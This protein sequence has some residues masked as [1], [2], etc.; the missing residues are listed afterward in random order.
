MI[1]DRWIYLAVLALLA[2]LTFSPALMEIATVAGLIGWVGFKMKTGLRIP[3]EK[4]IFYPF[5]GY[6]LLSSLSFFWSQYPAQS[7]RGIFKVLQQGF[8]FWLAVEAV[9]T[10]QRHQGLLGAVLFLFILTGFDG[11]WQLVSV[12]DFLRHI[13][14]EPASSG[15]RVSASFKNYGLLAAYCVTFLPVLISQTGKSGGKKTLFLRC[16][17][18]ALGLLLLFWTRMRGAWIAFWLGGLFFLCFE[19]KKI[20]LVCFLL[21]SAAGVLAL[22]RAMLIHLDAEGKEQSLVERFYLW[23]RAIEVIEAKPLTGT[24]INTYAVAHQEFD[25]RHNWR[26]RNYYAHNGYL[27]MAA[28]TGLPTL[29]LFLAFLFFYFLETMRALRA[30]RD[31]IE[32]RTLVGMLTG[33]LNFMLF[34]M[35]DTIFHNEVSVLAFW[36]LLGWGMAYRKMITAGCPAGVSSP[37][38]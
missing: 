19:R 11:M 9:N 18:I 15:A 24:G 3:F 36:F 32:R 20:Y 12:F 5:A 1:F 17:G 10:R 35:I 16:L 34:G 29:L 21:L 7:F 2:G 14:F 4:K 31:E 22:P 37:K 8:V 23:D 38:D 13:H 26:V 25:Q 6:V 33:I 28:E 30:V 27:Q